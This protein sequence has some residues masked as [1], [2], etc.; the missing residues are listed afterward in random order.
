[1]EVD[2]K[3]NQNN[4]E[5]VLIFNQLN[6]E[7]SFDL[8]SDINME[9]GSKFQILFLKYKKL[10][11]VQYKSLKQLKLREKDFQQITKYL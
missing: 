2:G 10:F 9:R 1:M 7:E 5:A 8:D 3:N 6:N 11:L 4:R